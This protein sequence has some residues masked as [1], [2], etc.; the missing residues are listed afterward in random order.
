MKILY[1]ILLVYVCEKCRFNL[2]FGHPMPIITS[3]SGPLNCFHSSE[4]TFIYD[5]PLKRTG[6]FPGNLMHGHFKLVLTMG[7]TFTLSLDINES[8]ETLPARTKKKAHFLSGMQ[9][10]WIKNY[11]ICVFKQSPEFCP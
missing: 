5:C 4:V 6:L 8:R 11:V 2:I 1:Q 7:S 10:A 9:N 3:S